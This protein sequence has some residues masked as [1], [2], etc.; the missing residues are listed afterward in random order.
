MSGI[1][2][3]EPFGAVALDPYHKWL[4]IPPDEQPP[5]YYRLLGIGLYES[6]PE[7]VAY[8]ADAR[9]SHV[10]TFQSGKH[11]A[12]SQ[13]ILNEIASAKLCLLNP[14]KKSEYDRWLKSQLETSC[15][16]TSFDVPIVVPSV[17][18]TSIYA[19]SRRKRKPDMFIWGSLLGMAA[20]VLIVILPIYVGK[21]EQTLSSR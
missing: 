2:S 4:G 5:N 13:R 20:V 14:T 18:P 19:R 12:I 11:S 3:S 21:E 1:N 10:K 6:D 8:A 17:T 16:E 9:M 7:V 15:P